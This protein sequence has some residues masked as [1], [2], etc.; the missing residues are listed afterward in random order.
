MALI[1]NLAKSQGL[2]GRLLE[3]IEELD[4]AEL[5]NLIHLLEEKNFKD[6]VDFVLFYEGGE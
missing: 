2:Y 3:T 1:R 6:P 5:E 4:V